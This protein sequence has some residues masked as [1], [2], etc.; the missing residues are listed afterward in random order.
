[1]KTKALVGSLFAVTLFL[2]ACGGDDNQKTAQA[3]SASEQV[4]K[5]GVC[6]GPYG[7]MVE[8]VI[9]PL[10]TEE[11]YKVEVIT[12]SDYV[13]PNLALDS[14][15]IQANLFQHQAYFDNFVETQGVKLESVINVPTLGMGVFSANIKSYDEL[16]AGDKV[17]IANDPVNLGRSLDVAQ[18]AGLI[19]LN[20]QV[21]DNKASIAD[22]TENKYS[23]EFVPMDAAQI[24]RSLDSV[25]IGFVPGNFAYAANLDFSKALSV[26]DVK[27]PIK[28]VVAVKADNKALKDL[29]Y[30]VIHSQKFKDAI[31]KDSK[32][33]QFTR[34]VWW[35]EVAATNESADTAADAAADAA[36]SDAAP[37]ADATPADDAE[38]A[39]KG[40]KTAMM[41]SPKF[42]ETLVK[43]AA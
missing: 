37:A 11:G 12:F 4:M 14:G 7:Y 42:A 8:S 13:Q 5:V 10:L 17:A 28:N 34:P 26:E 19:K 15:D 3:T 40:D 1:M 24:A 16:K 32:F 43:V 41:L 9:A 30:K 36:A 6:P 29:F 27:E 31:V 20:K 18:K 2:T 25:A 23:L 35:D 33:D 22:I 21:N 39:A 38:D